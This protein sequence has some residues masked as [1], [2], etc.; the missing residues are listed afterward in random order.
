MSFSIL[1]LSDL[2]RDHDDELPNTW[3]IESLERDR[4][5]YVN[6][7]VPAPSLC[8]VTGD[9][10]FGADPTAATPAQEVARQYGQAEE[11]LARL[12]D[13]FFAGDRERIVLLPG[14][15]DV[16]AAVAFASMSRV[17]APA[18][19]AEKRRLAAEY[20]YPHTSLRW[21]WT[22][23]S[24]LRV[25]N[26][27]AYERRFE[28]FAE[29]YQRFYLGQRMYPLD[30]S[31]QYHV[32]DFPDLRFCILVLNSCHENDLLR[33]A[34]AIH[35]DCLAQ[36]TRELRRPHRTGWMTAA[37]WHHNL[38]G[39][40]ASNDYMDAS[41]LQLLIDSGVSL[42]FHG[43]QHRQE[44][45]DE[46]FR[47]G[48]SGRKISVVSSGTLCSGVRHL[49]PGT[50]RS[51]N[52]VTID[53]DAL[54]ATVHLRQMLNLPPAMPL[55]GPGYIV[56]T[57]TDHVEFPV[58]EPLAHRPERLDAALALERAEAL[59]G[60]GQWEDAVRCLDA[61]SKH[62]L[63]RPLLFKALGELGDSPAIF[64]KLWPPKN[65]GEA[66]VVADVILQGG[67]REFATSF[68]NTPEVRDSNDA[69]VR[70]V[71]RRVRERFLR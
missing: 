51:Y 1:H 29:F 50:P 5:K 46:R 56:A 22:E 70:E 21:S 32:F 3:L 64:S 27:A 10:I 20:Q 25:T 44:C 48:P 9:L 66:V 23:M 63:A 40:P 43:H 30:P 71:M 49:A 16:D 35:P 14:N 60:A 69:S 47:L 52:I 36:G 67:A 11:F 18:T 39:P 26:E 7:G 34:G 53:P 61:I 19:A 41:V 13:T 6:Q 15:H 4:N 31:L 33:R 57:G 2:H 37:A 8:L 55:W 45:V 28:A 58:C 68:L 54:T 38:F 62:P 17:D 59:I 65:A 42:A 12:A 24:F